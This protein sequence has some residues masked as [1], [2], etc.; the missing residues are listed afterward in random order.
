MRNTITNLYN[1]VSAPV[2]ATHDAL[3]KKLDSVRGTVTLLYNRLKD[4]LGY[5]QT[6]KGIIEEQAMQ[7]YIGI[8][9][10]KHLYPKSG[11][12]GT[13]EKGI[14]DIKHLY[15][16]SKTRTTEKG[17]EDIKHLYR[18]SKTGT[19]EEATDD[20]QYLYDEHDMS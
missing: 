18:K 10:I 19:N 9:D 7:D 12:T 17:I 8:E 14:E 1:A 5:G 16:K 4:K 15:P 13:T 6:L 3:R 2:A 20:V 11:R